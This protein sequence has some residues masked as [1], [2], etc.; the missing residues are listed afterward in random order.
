[1][2]ARLDNRKKINTAERKVTQWA[3]SPVLNITRRKAALH[4]NRGPSTQRCMPACLL[5]MTPRKKKTEG[6]KWSNSQEMETI[7]GI[8][9]VADGVG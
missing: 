6:R 7:V 2:Q 3:K 9:G 5:E 8:S 4:N 1:M